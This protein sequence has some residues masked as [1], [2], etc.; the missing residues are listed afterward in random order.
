MPT[1]SGGAAPLSALADFVVDHGPTAINRYDRTRRVT[2]E[3]D[4]AGDAALGDAVAAI[5]ALPA[6]SICRPGSRSARPATSK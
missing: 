5:H 4:L 1:G 3:G 2:I 6:A